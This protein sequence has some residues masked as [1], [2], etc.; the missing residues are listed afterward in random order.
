MMAADQ[1]G[2]VCPPPAPQT[3]KAT[4]EGSE[5][6]CLRGSKCLLLY[7]GFYVYFFLFP[8]ISKA[9]NINQG[10]ERNLKKFEEVK[11]EVL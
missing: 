4:S 10:P 2:L 11:C 9:V 7:E 6:I 1:P 3:G 8:A 5:D